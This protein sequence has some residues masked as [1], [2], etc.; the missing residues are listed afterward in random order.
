[1]FDMGDFDAEMSIPSDPSLDNYPDP[2]CGMVESLPSACFEVYALY[3]VHRYEHIVKFYT[4]RKM[5]KD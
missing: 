2:Y 4:D 3:G 1:M 5:L